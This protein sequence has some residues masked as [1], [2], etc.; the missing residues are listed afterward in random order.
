VPQ[1][2]CC[3]EE[4]R[5]LLAS[6]IGQATLGSRLRLVGVFSSSVPLVSMMLTTA[7]VIEPSESRRRDCERRLGCVSDLG[8]LR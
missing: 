5:Y 4:A 7:F 2:T 1:R 8:C 6:L 3:R